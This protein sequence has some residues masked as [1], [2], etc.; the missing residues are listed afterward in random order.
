MSITSFVNQLEAG[1]AAVVSLRFAA[2]VFHLSFV[3]RI[4]T[5]LTKKRNEKFSD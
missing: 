5:K 1:A 2:D 3:F 4:E